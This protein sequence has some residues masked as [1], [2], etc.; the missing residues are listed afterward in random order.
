MFCHSVSKPK[1]VR[2]KFTTVILPVALYGS[3]TW[4]LVRRGHQF[5]DARE[6]LTEGNIRIS[7]KVARRWRSFI[8]C[9]LRQIL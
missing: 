8:I 1:T 9:A 4:Y 5:E 7:E 3:G 6:Q 2:L